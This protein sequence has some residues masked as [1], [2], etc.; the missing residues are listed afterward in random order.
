MGDRAVAALD[1]PEI[2]RRPLASATPGATVITDDALQQASGIP[3]SQ[4]LA[5]LQQLQTE[6]RGQA[7]LAEQIRATFGGGDR[8]SPGAGANRPGP[9][10]GG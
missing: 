4:Q 1:N 3:N 7:Q 9:G 10:G 2:E 8:R 5:A 6:Q